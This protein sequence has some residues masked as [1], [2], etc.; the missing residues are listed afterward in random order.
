MTSSHPNLAELRA[1]VHKDHHQ[2]IGNWL[3]R[4]WGRPAGVYGTWLAV[5]LGLS[6]H[7]V[8]LGA[9]LSYLAAA[10]AI[11][12]GRPSGFLAGTLLAFGG[13]W[14]DHVDGQLARWHGTAGLGGVYYDYLLHH[15]FHLAVGFALGYGLATR[16]GQPPW[17]IAGF[18]IAAGWTLLSL[19]NDCRYKAF[20]QRLKLPGKSFRVD[21]GS[22][23]RPSPAPSWPRR[24]TGLIAWPASKL[25]EAHVVL[26][27]LAALSATLLASPTAWVWAWKAYVIALAA[28]APLLAAVRLTRCVLRNDVPAEF[29]RW[30]QPVDEP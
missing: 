15:V 20:F 18:L 28:V 6:A 11:G 9:L 3:A 25:C 26:A 30:F 4:R 27:S 7:Q 14:L 10:L 23:A 17:A 16:T 13:F 8:T 2:T 5:R 21:G 12:T 22:G 19:H 24:G 1:R 29:D